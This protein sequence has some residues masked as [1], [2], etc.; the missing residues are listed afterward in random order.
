MAVNFRQMTEVI[1]AINASHICDFLY[2]KFSNTFA[3]A[4]VAKIYENL[5]INITI[6]QINKFKNVLYTTINMAAH[7]I[8]VAFFFP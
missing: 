2:K 8:F 6:C 5:A 4:S 1:L 3:S 7:F